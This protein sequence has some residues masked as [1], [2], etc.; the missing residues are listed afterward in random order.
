MKRLLGLAL[1]LLLFAP[2]GIASAQEA[3]P[4]FS[5]TINCQQT[6][7]EAGHGLR[8]RIT[9]TTLRPT[10]W[11]TA[12]WPEIEY[13]VDVRNAQGQTPPESRYMKLLKG[14]DSSKPASVMVE[15]QPTWSL[16]VLAPAG[17]TYAQDLDVTALYDLS[18]PGHYSVQ[19]F[20]RED[21]TSPYRRDDNRGSI[22]SN[23]LS[24]TIVPVAAANVLQSRA[25]GGS[26]AAPFSITIWPHRRKLSDSFGVGV[27]TKNIS[28]HPIAIGTARNCKDL[29]GSVYKVDLV[30]ANGNPPPGTELGISVGNGTQAPPSLTLSPSQAYFGRLETLRPGEEWHDPACVDYLY[31][32][33]QPGEYT[34]QVRRWDPETRTWVRSNA[35]TDTYAP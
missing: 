32:L 15:S 14:T 1:P 30:D 21:S 16:A 11:S 34:V 28:D 18:K 23:V 35:I 4:A 33:R 19:V 6:V 26:P 27:V 8:L 10:L 2:A 13:G 22:K 12:L 3:G 31:T 29:L 17:A 20:R 24:L 9:T 5:I 7:A 25:Q